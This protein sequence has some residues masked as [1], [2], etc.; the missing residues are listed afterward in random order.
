[1]HTA[2]IAQQFHQ[3]G[4]AIVRG[5]FSPDELAALESHLQEHI[6][7]V[8]PRLKPGEVYYEDAPGKPIKSIFFLDRDVPCF[9]QLMGD[10]R[11][12]EIMQAIYAG[13]NVI[14]ESVMF[15]GKAARVGSV[16]PPHQDNAFQCWQPP[17]A[18]TATLALDESTPDNGVLICQK[19][20]HKAGLLPHR[21]SGVMGFSQTLIEP[22]DTVAYPEVQ[23]CM[24]PG[25]VSLHH[26]NTVHRSGPNRT[27]RSRRQF[28]IG[29]RASRAQRDEVRRAKYKEALEKLHAQAKQ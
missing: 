9:R 22:L 1:M 3:D 18:L 19:G 20:S 4:F 7:T 15:F 16:T 5:L 25:D 2:S 26:I 27:D 14:Q 12:L 28:G 23:L 29:Y 11:L 10:P 8:V 6:Q 24:K 21:P 13:A 17:E